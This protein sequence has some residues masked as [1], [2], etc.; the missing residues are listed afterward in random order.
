MRITYSQIGAFIRIMVSIIHS[1][2]GNAAEASHV[3]KFINRFK[4]SDEQ[5]KKLQMIEPY[6]ETEADYENL[7]KLDDTTKQKLSNILFDVMAEDGTISDQESILFMTLMSDSEFPTPDTQIWL[8]W[9][10]SSE[11]PVEEID[12]LSEEDSEICFFVIKAGGPHYGGKCRTVINKQYEYGITDTQV[13]KDILNC[14]D[15]V[16]LDCGDAEILD[17][18]TR[19]MGFEGYGQFHAYICKRPYDS[20]DNRAASD[21]FGRKIYGHCL[22]RFKSDSGEYMEMN[23]AQCARMFDLLK[24]HL[25]CKLLHRT[26]DR[27]HFHKNGLPVRR[28][29][30]QPV[31]TPPLG[32]AERIALWL[33][34]DRPEDNG[35]DLKLSHQDLLNDLDYSPSFLD[36]EPFETIKDLL[37]YVIDNDEDQPYHELLTLAKGYRMS[38]ELEKAAYWAHK[39]IVLGETGLEKDNA[40]NFGICGLSDANEEL[41]NCYFSVPYSHDTES[42]FPDFKKAAH[43]Y[44]LASRRQKYIMRGRSY[45]G[46]GDYQNAE[47][48][49][50][51]GMDD[52]EVMAW[53][54]HLC[55]LRHQIAQ[56]ERYWKKAIQGT[57]GWG[58]YFYGRYLWNREHYDTAISLWQQ[59]EKK[60]CSEC[61]GELFN[62]IVGH[63]QTPFSGKEEIWNKVQGLHY[64]DECISGYKYIYKHIG[65]GNIPIEEDVDENGKETKTNSTIMMSIA[66]YDGI[67]KFCPYCLTQVRSEY[68]MYSDTEFKRIL[69]AWGYNEFESSFSI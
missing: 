28:L 59:G 38:C 23:K 7:K 17:I 27:I 15:H 37:M 50:S 62:W 10:E 39:A 41:G 30:R 2:D 47:K 60:G 5:K 4:L 32:D 66:L 53:M 34:A 1:D 48:C 14:K 6:S 52:D 44:Y 35:F 42:S 22:I 18:L 29:S 49:F 33:M 25:D 54:G 55:N 13:A 24:Q 63:P 46:M 8:D 26:E 67:K 16:L 3:A 19:E 36:D 21:I 58:E 69:M 57:S 11:E 61:T 56:A 45:L 68:T 65:N 40:W 51:E 43:H 31:E 12:D 64:R 9:L 20:S